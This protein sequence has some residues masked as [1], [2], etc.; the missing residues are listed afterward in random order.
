MPRWASSMRREA[1]DVQNVVVVHHSFRRTTTPTPELLVEEFHD[2]HHADISTMF[3]HDSCAIMDF[4]KSI[5]YDIELLRASPAVPKH[6]KLY[7]L[8]YEI[9]SGKLTGVV[10]DIPAQ[11]AA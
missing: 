5:K 11:L 2:H 10:R 6:I 3:D 7:G 1:F 8:F 4:E 9:S